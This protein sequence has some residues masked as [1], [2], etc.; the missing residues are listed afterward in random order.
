[1]L[2]TIR[3][4]AQGWIAWAIVILISIP[5]ALWGIQEYLGVGSEPVI[6]KVNDREI[7]ER[8]VESAAFRLRNNLRQQLGGQYDADMFPESTLRKQVLESMIQDTLIHDAAKDLGMRA[9]DA[10]VRQTIASVPAFQVAGQFNQEAYSRAVQLQG[11]TEQGFEEQIRNSL[12]SQQLERSIQGSSFVTESFAEQAA[13]LGNQKRNI[14]YVML[15]AGQV[16]APAVPDET[17]INAFYE[18]NRIN[19]MSEERVKLEYLLLNLDTISKTLNATEEEL[20]GYYDQHKSEFVVP[21]KKRLSHILFEI[22]EEA[23]AEQVAAVT[24]KAIDVRQRLLQGEAFNELAKS[25]SDDIASANTGGDL[26]FL[27]PGL[28]DQVFETAAG[29]LALDQV[30]E[31]VRTRFGLHLIKVTELNKGSGED[32]EAVKEQVKEQYLKTEAEQIF[33]D[34][35]ERLANLSYETPDSLVPASEDLSLP[36]Q[37]SEWVTRSAGEGILSSPKVTGA[38]FSEEAISQGYNSETLELSPTELLV[39]RVIE[40][41]EANVKPLVEVRDEIVGQ[42]QR[43]ASFTAIEAL[44]DSMIASLQNGEAIENVAASHKVGIVEKNEM[45]RIET[46]MP[47]PLVEAVF[48]MPIPESAKTLFDKATVGDKI[49][50]IALKSVKQGDAEGQL[51]QLTS[52]LSQQQGSEEFRLYIETLRDKADIEYFKQL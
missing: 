30:S 14:A 40:H 35:A 50:V 4:K 9:G 2:M 19:F 17:A 18:K 39:L 44:A 46:D 22:P 20:R 43:E 7:T 6:A 16:E 5:F 47:Q 32:Y 42:L 26:G 27:E 51:Q 12:I 36:V 21:D 24:A 31:P 15:S 8:E 37:Q 33:Y 48:E 29:Q 25:S 1:M 38:A 34:Y 10:M 28:F 49:A 52:V 45:T 3:D 41:E 23:S 11:T 13:K